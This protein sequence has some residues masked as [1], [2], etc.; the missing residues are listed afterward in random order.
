MKRLHTGVIILDG[1]DILCI[2][3]STGSIIAYVYRKYRNYRKIKITGEDPI[4]DELKK[5]LQ[6]RCF[7]KK[8]NL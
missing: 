6:Y 4:I 3:F 1:I 8:V 7:M 5:N 2:S